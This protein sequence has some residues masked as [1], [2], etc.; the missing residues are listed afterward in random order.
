MTLDEAVR[1]FRWNPVHDYQSSTERDGK[2]VALH[3][4][5]IWDNDLRAL[6]DMVSN[7]RVSTIHRVDHNDGAW[8]R[9]NVWEA[10]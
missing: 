9:V 8:L 7:M 2:I 4:L 5:G 3:E 1:H 10:P 6:Y